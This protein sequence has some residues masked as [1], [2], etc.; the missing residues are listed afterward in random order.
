MI[1]DVHGLN[2]TAPFF[3]FKP[4]KKV[5]KTWTEKSKSIKRGGVGHFFFW[6]TSE[7]GEKKCLFGSPE[8]KDEISHPLVVVV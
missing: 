3:H 4:F 1:L 2:Q 7:N 8:N 6:G 5:Q